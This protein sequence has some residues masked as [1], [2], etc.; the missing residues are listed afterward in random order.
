MKSVVLE[1]M[2]MSQRRQCNPCC[3]ILMNSAPSQ[4]DN[5]I[6]PRSS[7]AVRLPRFAEVIVSSP[8]LRSVCMA[9]TSANLME[10][11]ITT[12]VISHDTGV[13]LIMLTK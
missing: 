8:P 4:T 10:K 9:V 7:S 3:L 11:L 1:N 13:N 5:V 12:G 2:L 6:T